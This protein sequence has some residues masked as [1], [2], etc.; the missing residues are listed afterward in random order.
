[1]RA[2]PYL[3][4][5]ASATLEFPLTK[6]SQ[7]LNGSIRRLDDDVGEHAL[8]LVDVMSIIFS[9]DVSVGGREKVFH[10]VPDTG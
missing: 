2:L 7:L 3:I 1:M 5:S 8:P 6:Y 10:V 4:S 9:L